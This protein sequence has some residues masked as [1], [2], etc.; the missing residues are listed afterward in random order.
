MRV[1]KFLF[2][3][4]LVFFCFNSLA[5]A[6]PAG[7]G[8]AGG[9]GGNPG[10]GGMDR[11]GSPSRPEPR[12][13]TSSSSKKDTQSFNGMRVS[14]SHEQFQVV[15]IESKEESLRITFNI[16]V[17]PKT[18]TSQNILIDGSPL[19]EATELKFNKTGKMLEIKFSLLR[20]K[21]STL[22][23]KD[24]KS[25]DGETLLVSSFSDLL[26]GIKMEYPEVKKEKS[27]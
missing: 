3:V 11:G 8:G 4:S 26:L 12:R 27:K 6:Q 25:F 13:S 2:V 1:G 14:S 18:F 5:L 9:R 24:V 7:G 23:F 21:N 16:P 20:G 17:D 10:G 15:L 22:E 19:N